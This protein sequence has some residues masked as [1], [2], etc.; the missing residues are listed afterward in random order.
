MRKA[1]RYLFLLQ[2]AIAYVQNGLQKILIRSGE[3]E[4]AHETIPI[5]ISGPEAKAS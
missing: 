3:K 5:P 1:V 4:Y 2:L